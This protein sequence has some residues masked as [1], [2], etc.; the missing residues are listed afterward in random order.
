MARTALQTPSQQVSS[1]SP[2]CVG[3]A[4]VHTP[5]LELPLRG[6]LTSCLTSCTLTTS[7]L[8][9]TT[10][11]IRRSA[12]ECRL[13]WDNSEGAH[14]AHGPWSAAEEKLLIGLVTSRTDAASPPD[15]LRLADR[16][17]VALGAAKP[18]SA[19][20]CMVRL[21]ATTQKRGK[22]G[23]SEREGFRAGDE[24]ARPFRDARRFPSTGV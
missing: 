12:A 2:Q 8:L 19:I 15:W 5:R 7:P 14:L 22:V 3:R 11:A 23:E 10:G 6:H 9:Q 1:T 24:L 13:A 16:L 4:G 18:R 17:R 21:A 20:A